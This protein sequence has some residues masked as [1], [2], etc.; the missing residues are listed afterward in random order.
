MIKK[1][2]ERDHKS[3]FNNW[4]S[5]KQRCHTWVSPTV[6][7]ALCVGLG[8]SWWLSGQESACQPRDTSS[9]PES[10]RSLGE[11]NGNPLQYSCLGNLMDRGAWWEALGSSVH[12]ISQARILEWVAI[13]FSRRSSPRDQTHISCI[14]GW[15]LYHWATWKPFTSLFIWPS[16]V[17]AV[18]HGIFSCGVKL[19][20]VA[21]GV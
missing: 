4:P 16:W 1:Y 5:W 21:C 11:R 17:L 6:N 13:L 9:I 8:L 2:R 19:L 3:C 15:I 14:G 12:E 20:V 7:P 18:P 10:E